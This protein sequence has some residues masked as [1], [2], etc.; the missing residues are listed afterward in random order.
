MSGI[1]PDW[2]ATP[3]GVFLLFGAGILLLLAGWGRRLPPFPGQAEFIRSQFGTAWWSLAAAI[4]TMVTAAADKVFWAEMAWPGIIATLIFWTAFLWGY[5]KGES[6]I[7]RP[8]IRW[9]G[10]LLPLAMWLMALT[11]PWHHLVYT[12]THPLNGLPGAPVLY[13]HGILVFAVFLIAYLLLAGGTLVLVDTAQQAPSSYRPH[14]FALIGALLFPWISSIG[15]LTRTFMPFG[16]DATPFSF[17]ITAA[18]FFWMIHRR[19]LFVLPPIALRPLL[20]SLPE[21]VLVADGRGLVVEANEGARALV[22]AGLRLGA[23][24]AEVLPIPL[25]A[26]ADDAVTIA[27]IRL[28]G[29]DERHFEI[30]SRSLLYRGRR[31]GQVVVLSDITHRKRMERRLREQLDMNLR[32]QQKLREQANRDLLT[33]L[34]NRHFLEE[35]RPALLAE[36]DRSGR[37]LSVVLLDLDH[38][39]R[40]NDTWGHQAGDEVLRAIASFLEA[41]VRDNDSVIRFG[42]EEILVLL[43]ETSLAQAALIAERWR[44][45]FCGEPV[46][47]RGERLTVT[48]SAGVA[49]YPDGAASWDELVQHA[50]LALYQAKARGRNR[51]CDW[52]EVED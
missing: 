11:N 3:H 1:I 39:K 49:S 17:V 46:P 51:V 27:D 20:D 31:V 28:D 14:Y 41:H 10:R 22:G 52:S 36:A 50:D 23:P 40:L 5:C 25:P 2:S 35:V 33:G 26:A 48:F 47:A 44:V 43:P 12:A 34:Y 9:L 19:H 15:H 30:R 37:P 42:G 8:L 32:L 21:A 38:F 6:P 13:D 4:E 29:D 7:R 16:F 45:R 24:L 18:I